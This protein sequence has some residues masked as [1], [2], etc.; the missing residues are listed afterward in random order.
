MHDVCLGVNV[1][2]G[3]GEGGAIVA[4]KG[5]EAFRDGRGSKTDFS[6]SD[7][8]EA[9]N[10]PDEVSNIHDVMPNLKRVFKSSFTS[11][12]YSI[13]LTSETLFDTSAFPSF[14]W[15]ENTAKK[16]ANCSQQ[17][18]VKFLFL[19]DSLE[20]K[21]TSRFR[22]LSTYFSDLDRKR[23]GCCLASTGHLQHKSLL[24]SKL[25]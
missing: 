4:F 15:R 5:E 8:N 21:L 13:T 19:S 9:L 18:R 11:S 14:Q 20:M 25:H 24:P 16:K 6:M 1:A 7:G 2:L 23:A 3:I 17:R 10:K 22:R 12:H